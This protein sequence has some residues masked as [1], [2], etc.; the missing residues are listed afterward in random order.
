MKNFNG[1]DLYSLSYGIDSN[2]NKCILYAS[3]GHKLMMFDENSTKSD[4][5]Q[6]MEFATPISSVS[7]CEKYIAI[8]FANGMTKILANN[9]K[10][11]V[12]FHFHFNSLK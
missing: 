12:K 1:K 6:S 8:G 10:K 4:D 2:T 3:N 9:T 7:A 5:H 11:T